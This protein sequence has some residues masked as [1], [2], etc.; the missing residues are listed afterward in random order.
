MIRPM[1]PENINFTKM[2]QIR[3]PHFNGLNIPQNYSKY[4]AKNKEKK[5]VNAAKLGLDFKMQMAKL[6]KLWNYN[7]KW[8]N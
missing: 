8:R 3:G 7:Y 2:L 6:G 4:A 1:S 5:F